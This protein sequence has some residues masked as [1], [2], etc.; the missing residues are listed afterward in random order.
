MPVPPPIDPARW[1]RIDDIFGEV[2]DLPDA[3]QAA[4]TARLCG[5][6]EALAADVRRLVQHD[7]SRGARI[8]SVL[9]GVAGLPL[10]APPDMLG[11][12]IGPYR[13]ERELGRG[14]MGIVYEGVRDDDFHQRVALK[15]AARAAF[16]P[17]LLARFRDE[18][19]IL[20]RLTHPRIA[21][22]LDGGTTDDGVPWFAMEF[23]DGVPIHRHCEDRG[24]TVPERLALFLQVC[25]AVDYAHQN[26]VVHRDLKPANVLVT[27]DGVRLLDFGIAKLLQ[28]AGHADGGTTQAAGAAVTPDYASPEQVTG[29][30]VTTRTD[31]YS[32]GLVLFE[33]LTGV[34]AHTADTS[35]PMALARS[36]C[37]VEVARPSEAAALAGRPVARLLRGDLDT[38]VQRATQTDPARRYASVAALADDVR[39]HLDG[40]A[41]VARQDSRAYR[42]R[43][44]VRRNWLPVAAGAALV[45]SLT[46]GIVA[47][48][49][50]ARQ[51]E[52]RFEQV[53]GI[54]RAMTNDVY[55]AIRDLPS[56][57]R[58]QETVLKTA[59]EYLD[60]LAR[61]SGNDRALQ[62]EIADGYLKASEIAYSLERPSL[63]RPVEGRRYVERAAVLLAPFEA[64]AVSDPVVAAAVVERYRLTADL[65]LD[66]SRRDAALA[67]LRRGVEL[68]DAA[69]HRSPDHVPLLATVQ[70]TLIELLST[71]NTNAWV[72]T[73]LPR[74]IEIADHRLRLQPDEDEALAQLAVTYSQA[75]NVES[76]R[77]NL[78]LAQ[79]YYRKAADLHTRI[80]E[81]APDNVTARRNR[82]I[83]LANLADVL[84]GPL[85]S[86]SYTGA[87]G[88]PRPIDE[89]QR[90]AALDAMTRACAEAAYLFEKDRTNDTVVFD[91][92]I[93]RGRSAPAYPPADPRAVDALTD[94]LARLAPL[95]ARHPARV[96][97]YEIEFRGSLA[98]R[99]RQMGAAAR[100]DEEWAR[101]DAIVRRAAAADADEYYLQ[102]LAIPL[103][104]NQAESMVARGR[105]ADAR[106][107]MA[108][109]EALADA[110]GR[111]PAYARGPGWPPR[112]RAWH[113]DLLRRMGD[114]EGAA[115]AADEAR[116]MWQALA[117]RTDLVD[118][119][120]REANAAADVT[121]QPPMA[122]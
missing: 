121:G 31:V 60:G 54:A 112:V 10:P 5:G 115:R 71:F 25:D 6:D 82:M 117:A 63:G 88:P 62:I 15:L 34:R 58:A 13:I 76:A 109:V 22:L 74:A 61:E 45:A 80:V 11:R 79:D 100:A 95:S 7:R 3:E 32:L 33:L 65:E 36:I 23:V 40:R 94:A 97:V 28:Q 106:R 41:I 9:E 108:R 73:Q 19:Q 119:L 98:E 14:G 116:A 59:I 70:D 122:R 51:A 2:V 18:R 29:Q 37:D 75:G 4:A 78:T 57:T 30:P 1:K 96:A 114:A 12:R 72:M 24:L 44:F 103:V 66:A 99:Y 85:G 84:L 87:G 39:R 104:E 68:G 92:A 83:V 118:D 113:A 120:L 53:R 90:A 52:R 38:I 86:A 110:V 21:R 26:L 43:R 93:C 20:A 17:D 69:L 16:A 27:A 81:R 50:Q 42:L 105:P 64:E 101:A 91:L 111:S 8:H 56:S 107:L 77:E 67:H 35:S 47:T 46:G 102:R 48:R 49:Y 55:A 89:G